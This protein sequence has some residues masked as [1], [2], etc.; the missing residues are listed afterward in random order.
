MSKKEDDNITNLVI[1]GF[2]ILGASLLFKKAKAGAGGGGAWSDYFNTADFTK[3][4]TAK[5]EGYAEQYTPTYEQK[6]LGSTFAKMWLDPT[7]RLYG[8]DRLHIESW[9]RAPRTNTK[10]GGSDTSGHLDGGT[11]DFWLLDTAGQ[12]I[13]RE[14]FKNL[15]FLSLDPS[16]IYDQMILEGGTIANPRVIHFSMRSGGRNNNRKQILYTPDGKTYTDITPT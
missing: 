7:A 5:R 15:L 13:N 6:K 12:R 3:S 16:R 2:G 10:V 14:L 8:R 11:V 4:D 9:F 1:L